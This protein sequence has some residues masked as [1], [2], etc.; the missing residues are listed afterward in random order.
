MR[1]HLVVCDE[2]LPDPQAV[3]E[4]ALAGKF[5]DV[6][7]RGDLYEGV[8]ESF[9]DPIDLVSKA[10]GFDVVIDMSF[11][12]NSLMHHRPGSIHT[13]MC[14]SNWAGILYLSDPESE[15]SGTAFW[16][17][18]EL[19]WDRLPPAQ[20]MRDLGVEPTLEFRE[21]LSSDGFDESKWNLDTV[22]GMKYN[23]F[24][25][26]PTEYFHS[27]YPRR[28]EATDFLDGRLTWVCF[29]RDIDAIKAQEAT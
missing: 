26:Y 8:G 20:I 4:K 28:N 27:R 11:F 6:E 19:G 25:A 14:E 1:K 9:I 7:Y 21:N 23:R 16:T 15:L 3:L 18:K 29:F 17:H 13:D 10:V 12:R 2:F 5:K 22:L 24:V